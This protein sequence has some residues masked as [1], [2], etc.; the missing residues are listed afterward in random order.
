MRHLPAES[1]SKDDQDGSR[2]QGRLR[3]GHDQHPEAAAQ[4]EG[5]HHGTDS[6]ELKTSESFLIANPE[7]PRLGSASINLLFHKNFRRVTEWQIRGMA[8]KIS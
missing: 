5:D 4:R 8:T 7:L 2:P 1:F 3:E 6:T